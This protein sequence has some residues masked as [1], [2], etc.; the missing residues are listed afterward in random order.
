MRPAHSMSGVLLN[1]GNCSKIIGKQAQRAPFFF[2]KLSLSRGCL[3]VIMNWK[4]RWSTAMKDK[5]SSLGHE[6]KSL[7]LILLCE[8]RDILTCPEN[9][10]KVLISRLFTGTVHSFS[11]FHAFIKHSVDSSWMNISCFLPFKALEAIFQPIMTPL[12][13][14]ASTLLACNVFWSKAAISSTSGSN[15]KELEEQGRP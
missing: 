9:P 13:L 14:L 4:V 7:W 12:L 6:L 11:G 5:E 10:L 8:W 2:F 15:I 1:L 3:L